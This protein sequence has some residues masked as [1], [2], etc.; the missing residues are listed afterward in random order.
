MG[1]RTTAR[2][3]R[4]RLRPVRPADA[5]LLLQLIRELADYEKLSHQ[6]VATP[7]GLRRALFGPRPAAEAVVAE[8]DGAPA[9]FALYFTNF[10]T[11]AGR[12]GIYLEDLYVKPALRGKGI[13]RRLLT[14]LARL[15]VRRGC[16]RFEW[17]VLD[18][19]EPAL[20]FYRSLGAR[21][22]TDWTLHRVDGAALRRL[23]RKP[24]AR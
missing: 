22:L 11:F 3:E 21:A 16:A 10:S 1:G 4:I 23:G 12:P 8:Y 13:G 5:A 18:W 24:R 7:A 2:R 15:A 20:R 9:G 14:H 17:A 19:N 6:V